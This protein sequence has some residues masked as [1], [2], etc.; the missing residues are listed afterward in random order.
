MSAF[1][2]HSIYPKS[3][4]FQKLEPFY[5]GYQLYDTVYDMWESVN[6]VTF[7]MRLPRNTMV[8]FDGLVANEV[9]AGRRFGGLLVKLQPERREL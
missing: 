9:F 4:F 8:R 1:A 2:M 7:R 5:W 6:L 3:K